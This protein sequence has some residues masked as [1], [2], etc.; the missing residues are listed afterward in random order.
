[1]AFTPSDHNVDQ[2]AATGQ[3]QGN[4]DLA[5][6][7][8]SGNETYKAANE[9]K[10]AAAGTD[11]QSMALTDVPVNQ[12]RDGTPAPGDASTDQREGN[13]HQDP[14][15]NYQ[16]VENR[17]GSTVEMWDNSDGSTSVKVNQ[18][19]GDGMEFKGKKEFT[20]DG[21]PKGFTINEVRNFD[22]HG[23]TTTT[24]KRNGTH[25]QG[26]NEAGQPAGAAIDGKIELER[27]FVM[28]FTPTNNPNA[29]RR[30]EPNGR[31]TWKF[32]DKASNQDF[33]LSEVAPDGQKV[34]MEDLPGVKDAIARDG[35]HQ[36]TQTNA[37]GSKVEYD[38]VNGHDKPTKVTMPDGSTRDYG[39][40]A[41]GKPNL[42][43]D[44]DSRGHIVSVSRPNQDG[45]GWVAQKGYEKS[46][47]PGSLTVEND[48][49]H[50]FL[51]TAGPAAGFITEILPNGQVAMTDKNGHI[52]SIVQQ[53][54]QKH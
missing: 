43:I 6:S 16:K 28:K 54:M 3:G 51:N 8:R 20:A 23:K 19:D 4:P 22:E 17:D 36:R 11:L 35:K 45:S 52:V 29:S 32:H 46:T 34:K 48:G 49:T 26:Y 40:T 50:K 10:L 30:V 25:W 13:D 2:P 42:V 15:K 31:E 41:D 12:G 39:Y 14:R 21:K 47:V 33:T 44:R 7:D 24:F 18:P 27:G 5:I 53:K 38:K 1:M 37:D 9:V